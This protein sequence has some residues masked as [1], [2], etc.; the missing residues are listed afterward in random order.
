M[1]DGLLLQE[2]SGFIL[3]EN[4]RSALLRLGRLK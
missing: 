4:Q 1:E 3:F 2:V